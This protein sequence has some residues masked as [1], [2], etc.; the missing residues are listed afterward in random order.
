MRIPIST[1]LITV[2]ILILVAATGAITW[3]SSAFFERKASEQVDIANLESA[4]GKAKE[5]E[6]IVGTLV[7]KTRV[8][9]S[10]LMKG[11]SN[12]TATGDDFDFSFTKDKNFIALDVL[13]ING[14]AVEVVARK[15][16]E[17]VLKSYNLNSQY[18]DNVRAWQK[19]PMRSV[20]QGSIELKNASYPKAPAMITIGVPLVRDSQGKITHIA[21]ADVT[22]SPFEKPFTDPSERTQFLVDRSGELLAHKD[23]QKAMARLNMGKNPFV[24]KAL[25]QKSPQYQTKFVDPDFE[26]NY[27]GAS[28][29]TSFGGAVVSLTS[30]ETILEVSHEVKRRAIFV[31]GSAISLAIFFIFLFS[32]TLTSP[33]EK[34]AEMIALVSKG[35]FDVKARTQVKSHD[36]V[37]DLAEAFDHMT[38]G[39]K[40]RD[41]VKSLFSKFHGSSVAEDLIGKDIGVGGQAKD[42]VVFFSDIRGFTAFSEKRSP[43]EVVEML[44]EY[45]AVMVKII[46]AHGG[47]VD[48]FIGDAI[49]A[50]WGA[51]K[52]SDRDCHKALRACLE[53]R[54]ALEELNE[55]R[56][57]RGQPAINIGMGLHAGT[58][59]SG[60]IGSDERMEYTVIGNTVNTA[61]R[62]EASTKAF[63]ADLLVTDSVIEKVG[64]DF[65]VDLAGAAEVKGRSDA[66]KMY[67]V[68]GYRAEDGSMVEVKTA[69]SDY[70]AEAADKVKVKA[71]A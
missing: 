65:K 17:D 66:I 46:N 8:S 41:K 50:I 34:L 33:I 69:Y 24:Q 21:L 53:M 25:V 18:I 63:G 37:G 4:A 64:E 23:E 70:E 40:E 52:S 47:V 12:E 3:I 26:K 35:N 16:K 29:K 27:F 44:N 49:M 31:A 5:I 60:T 19:F 42:V 39:L 48:K 58:A 51:P 2:T 14:S 45:F 71:A 22:L 15:V 36:E 54:K 38:E 10:L 55:K 28:V 6:N 59:I 43:E 30:E 32:M 7:E 56:I 1:K 11:T 9:A 67:K 62:I 57:A 68:R 61:S 13:K 20:A